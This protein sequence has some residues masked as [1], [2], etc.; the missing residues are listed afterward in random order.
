MRPEL[1]QRTAA[2][3]KGSAY[4]ERYC[5]LI[6]CAFYLENVGPESGERSHVKEG[7]IPGSPLDDIASWPLHV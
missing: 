4:L 3:K 5:V 2:F 6:A 1:Q 7:G